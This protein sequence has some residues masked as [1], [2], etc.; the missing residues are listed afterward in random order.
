MKIAFIWWWGRAEEIYPNWK[1]G[2]RAAID[3]I[4]VDN[5][6][7]IFL[8][9]HI[10]DEEYD[11]TIVWGDS[12]C[13]AIPLIKGK[14]GII[15]TTEP[16]NVDNLKLLDVIYCESQPIY[17]KVRALGLRAV[18]A[19][20]TDTE[21]YKPDDTVKDLKFFYPATF[22]PWKLQREIAF[23]GKDLLCIGTVQP[24]GVEDYEA[25]LEKGV[26]VKTGYFPPEVI[27]EGYK[28]TEKVLIPAIHGSER[29]CL[30][31]L[32]M[33]IVPEVNPNNIRTKSYVDEYR[34]SGLIPREFVEKFYSA[35]T[36]A[37]ALLKGM[38]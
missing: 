16:T 6:V 33:G 20:G 5:D 26:N 25:C 30:E 34:A 37:D 13:T 27:L 17:D 24:D 8:G 22:S 32:S 11:F 14:K 36:Y 4:G 12:N 29:T 23:H 28:R 1:D 15:L 2:L 10:P 7:D 21:F 31:S 9:E 18:K 19:F 38:Q 35:R 3:V